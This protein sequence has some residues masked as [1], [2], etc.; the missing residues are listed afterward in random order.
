MNVYEGMPPRLYR[1][2]SEI[3]RDMASVAAKIRENEEMLSVH[4]LLIEMIPSWATES[5]EKWIPELEE[6]IAEANDALDNL[7]RL[8]TALE[9]LSLELEDVRCMMQG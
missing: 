3:R 4:N 1:T 2:P 5:P 6:T 9:E 7:K 8:K